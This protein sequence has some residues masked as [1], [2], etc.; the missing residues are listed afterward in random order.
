MLAAA[1]LRYH[2]LLSSA[3][4]R[5]VTSALA[6]DPMA[7]GVDVRTDSQAQ[8]WFV[9]LGLP[10]RLDGAAAAGAN[11]THTGAAGPA[12]GVGSA[13]AQGAQLRAG[14]LPKR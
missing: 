5:A 14:A 6:S 3:A 11:G 1:G 13:G 12:A 4:A 2:E 7:A 9:T 10:S 8:E